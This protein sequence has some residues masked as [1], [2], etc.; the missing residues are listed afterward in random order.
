MPY[1]QYIFI[2]FL[3]SFIQINT[4]LTE[5]KHCCYLQSATLFFYTLE[6]QMC[7]QRTEQ[8]STITVLCFMYRSLVTVSCPLC[9]SLRTG[10]EGFFFHFA[11]SFTS[12]ANPQTL[13]FFFR[14]LSRIVGFLYTLCLRLHA[15]LL[16]EGLA[17]YAQQVDLYCSLAA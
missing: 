12:F 3:S 5:K 17:K 16:F 8:P 15:L 13:F 4:N 10:H 6:I 7:L 2:G 14:N 11:L 9:C 1:I